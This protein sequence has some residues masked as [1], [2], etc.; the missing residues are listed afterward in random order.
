M[1]N[2]K[3]SELIP[4]ANNSRTHSDEQINQIAASIDEFGFTNP[5]LVDVD[6]VI[7][8]GHGRAL[9]AERLG[10]VEVPCIVLA[11]LTP[12][13]IKAY[14]IADNKLALNASWDEELLKVELEELH[15]VGFE[16]D[17]IGF[18]A[19]ELAHILYD[20]IGAPL[21]P[22]VEPESAYKEQ[23]AVIVTCKDAAEQETV[24]N[25]LSGSGYDV[26]VVCT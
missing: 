18:N 21:K 22:S 3:V 13:Q 25:K 11:D 26:K 15:A 24:F 14:V 5:I 4:Y 16:L 23:Y 19:D 7:I 12:A 10:M 1:Q 9:A 6:G 17:V 20:E 8:A 2:R